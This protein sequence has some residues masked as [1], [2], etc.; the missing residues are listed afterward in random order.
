MTVFGRKVLTLALALSCAALPAAAARRPLNPHYK[1]P[2]KRAASRP[3][4]RS[5]PPP[6]KTHLAPGRWDPAV[7]AALEALARRAGDESP[8]YDA[9]APPI[10]VLTLDD[11]VIDG[12]LGELCFWK[13]VRRAQFKFGDKFWDIV[14]IVYGRQKTRAAYEQ[15]SSF[16]PEIWDAEPTYHQYCKDFVA[17]YHGI[18]ENVDRERCRSYL[19]RLW[20]GYARQDAQAYASS[21]WDEELSQAPRVEAVAASPS[22]SAPE[23]VRRGLRVAPELKDLIRFLRATGFDVWLQSPE[24]TALV[25][26]AAVKLGVDPDHAQGIRLTSFKDKLGDKALDPLPLREGKVEA[27]VRAAGREPALVVGT[28]PED[29]DLLSY[30]TGT[31]LLLDRGEPHLHA[32]AVKLGWLVQPSFVHPP[33][34]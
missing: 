24:Q 16:S 12:D 10:A 30:G 27:I 9:A 13:L 20:R 5:G 28:G 33:E 18:C 3:A 26:A 7:R 4:E 25:R 11:A 1:G 6:L 14:P 2:K 29:V 22:D 21:V 15:F 17:S 32:L 8:G 31:R 23:H 34:K 19:A